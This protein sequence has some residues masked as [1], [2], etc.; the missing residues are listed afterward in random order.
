[1][2]NE[3]R[4][5]QSLAMFDLSVPFTIDD[6][7]AH[8]LDLV[9]V[10]HPDR[11]N[12]NERLKHKAE[13]QLKRINAAFTELS[14]NCDA[15]NAQF[16][17][18]RSSPRL[19][20][21][22]KPSSEPKMENHLR[23]GQ[24]ALDAGNLEEAYR[25]NSKALELD[26]DCHLAWL[27]KG[28]AAGW[29]ST[30]L[31]PRLSEMCVCYSQAIAT[32]SPETRAALEVG[33]SQSKATIIGAYFPACKAA[34]HELLP[35]AG[36][37]GENIAP[38]WSHYL[39]LCSQLLAILEEVHALIPDEPIPMRLI[40][41]ICKDNLEGVSYTDYTTVQ[42]GSHVKRAMNVSPH[43]EE[44][45]RSKMLHYSRK[46]QTVEPSFVTPSPTKAS[47]GCFI[48]TCVCGSQDHP[49][50]EVLRKFRDH[51]LQNYTLGRRFLAFYQRHG[52]RLAALVENRPTLK[53]TI[54]TVLILP[55][56]CLAKASFKL[57]H[58]TGCREL[59][60]TPRSSVRRPH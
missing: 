25:H 12:H 10:W 34:L 30:F 56:S 23:L 3:E 39:G 11:H 16:S 45:L 47:P 18:K 28:T 54:F 60:V 19:K 37:D 41:A 51:K 31:E 52:P 49:C 32:A 43:F 50:V 8:Y 22:K 9:Q 48:A 57:S 53:K 1:M 26:A 21:S 5:K 14:E 7:K 29:M 46:V 44:E 35:T 36:V 27:G 15:I 55:A 42:F 13:E 58:E 2:E 33:I 40:V 38:P 20:R 17:P 4:T 6:L 24:L 59:S